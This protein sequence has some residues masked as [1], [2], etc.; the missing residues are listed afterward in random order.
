MLGGAPHGLPPDR[1]T[2][3]RVIEAG[4][5]PMPPPRAMN[6]KRLSGARGVYC[7]RSAMTSSTAG[8]SRTQAAVVRAAA[9]ARLRQDLAGRICC[10]YRGINAA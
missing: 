9:Q 4:D 10:D 1:G 5:A 3:A 7:A 8:G 2:T 6:L